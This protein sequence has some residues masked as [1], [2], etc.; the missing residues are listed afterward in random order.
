[1]VLF[2]FFFAFHDTWKL[3]NHIPGIIAGK[4][5][6]TLILEVVSERHISKD[7]FLAVDLIFHARKK[8]NYFRWK[9]IV[10]YSGLTTKRTTIKTK[11]SQFIQWRRDPLMHLAVSSPKLISA[12]CQNK[13]PNFE[14]SDN[15]EATSVTYRDMFFSRMLRIALFALNFIGSKEKHLESLQVQILKK[16]NWSLVSNT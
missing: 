10:Y 9:S 11:T 16:G 1:M 3:P 15:T 14:K 13:H 4:V 6:H 7:V 2:G 8:C 12:F 5:L